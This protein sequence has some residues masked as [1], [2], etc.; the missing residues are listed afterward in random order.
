MTGS[1][2]SGVNAGGAPP[3][4]ATARIASRPQ[5]QPINPTKAP[6]R[7]PIAV[8][9]ASRCS[10]IASVRTYGAPRALG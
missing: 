5:M 6:A 8:V 7:K 4:V 1:V 3:V 10:A 9:S 2:P